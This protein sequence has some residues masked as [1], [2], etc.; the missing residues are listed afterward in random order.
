MMKTFDAYA[1]NLDDFWGKKQILVMGPVYSE[2]VLL[3][4]L[5]N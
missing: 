4:L 2:M 5:W 1:Y 3:K